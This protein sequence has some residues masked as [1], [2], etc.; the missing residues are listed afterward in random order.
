LLCWAF[1]LWFYRLVSASCLHIPGMPTAP[2]LPFH[3]SFHPLVLNLTAAL[4]FSSL[5]LHPLRF[6]L[7]SLSEPKFLNAS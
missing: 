5:S 3:F 2:T 4:I 7:S 6:F 1:F